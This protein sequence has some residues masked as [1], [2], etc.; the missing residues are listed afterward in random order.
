MIKKIILSLIV[1][2]FLA[3]VVLA[4]G[5]IV[6]IPQVA[7]G[8]GLETTFVFMNLS[9]TT[10]RLEIRAFDSNGL[11]VELL[12]DPGSALVPPSTSTVLGVEVPGYGVTEAIT[13]T[14]SAQELKVGYAEVSSDFDEPFGVEAVF[15]TYA[16]NTLD[17]ASSVLPADPMNGFSFIAYA[18]G[19]NRTGIALLNPAGNEAAADV[20]MTLLNNNGDEVDEMA[21]SLEPGSK[22]TL[23]IDELFAGYFA[24]AGDFLGSV[25]IDSTRPVTA[26]ILKFEGS[27]M[28]TQTIQP[29]RSLD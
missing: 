13:L 23:F 28:T 2:L 7:H 5:D 26:T 17:T 22:T 27:F 19:V 6:Y 16:G 25:E 9:A 12:K 4:G 3:G 10:N 20:T 21:V 14:S 8:Q 11:P 29:S 18:D 24:T 15:K 1:I